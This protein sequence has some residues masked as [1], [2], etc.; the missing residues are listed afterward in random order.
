MRGLI[1]R[2]NFNYWFN[3]SLLM[4]ML[5]HKKFWHFVVRIMVWLEMMKNILM[6]FIMV[7]SIRMMYHVMRCLK[8]R[9]S[10]VMMLSLMMMC[11]VN[12][13]W[14]DEMRFCMVFP[15]IMVK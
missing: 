10:E 3:M 11:V 14:I 12:W 5:M 2:D 4:M 13:F 15:F 6:D 9:Y 8:I 7:R 1:S